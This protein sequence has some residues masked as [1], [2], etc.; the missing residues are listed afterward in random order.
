MSKNKKKIAILTAVSPYRASGIVSYDLMKALNLSGL[1]VTIYS[2]EYFISQDEKI[3]SLK[4]KFTALKI[5]VLRKLESIIFKPAKKVNR[6]YYMYGL[7]HKQK[8]SIVKRV[9]KK[10]LNN[11]DAIIYLFPQDFL[12][13]TELAYLSN[14]LNVPIFWQFMDMAPLT[15]GC[16]YAWD[17][18]GYQ[19]SCGNC[20]GIYSNNPSDETYRNIVIK[21][22]DINNS[23]IFPVV[24]NTFQYNQLNKSSVFKEKEKYQISLAINND[25]FKPDYSAKEDLFNNDQINIF[26]GAVS[27]A[28][29]RKGYKELINAINYIDNLLEDSKRKKIQVFV[30]GHK[31]DSLLSDIPFKTN[32]LGFLNYAKLAEAFKKASLFVCPSIEDSGPMMVNQ[33][34]MCGTP[35]VAFNQGT[36]MDFVINGKTGYKAKTKDYKELGSAMLKII[37]LKREDYLQMSLNCAAIGKKESSYQSVSKKW[38]EVINN[39]KY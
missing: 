35:V 1:D 31:I 30:A 5:K 28:E 19:K 17:C 18:K 27:V 13:S 34:I 38:F 22:N 14:K 16:H 33:A 7:I 20:P 36:A 11:C 39:H 26:F 8:K 3:V 24:A 25:I 23:R 4:T 2:S 10:L 29:K 15:G 21:Q 37:N 32:F 6:D 9:L 12:S